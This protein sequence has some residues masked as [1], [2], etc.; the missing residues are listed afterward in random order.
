MLRRHEPG[1]ILLEAAWAD[2]ATGL[3]DIARLGDF[4]RADQGA[5]PLQALDRVSPLAVPVLLE[6]G[7]ERSTGAARARPSC[8]EAAEDLIAGGHAA[9]GVTCMLELKPERFTS[10]RLDDHVAGR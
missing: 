3:L 6:I 2:A 4:L 9:E 1:H 10:A 5:H 7:R 8:A